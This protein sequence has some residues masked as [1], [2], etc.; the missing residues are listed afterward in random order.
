[1]LCVEAEH[2]TIRPDTSAIT[3]PTMRGVADKFLGVGETVFDMLQG[4]AVNS[5][6]FKRNTPPPP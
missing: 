2:C 5:S 6:Y 3:D 1:M 4:T